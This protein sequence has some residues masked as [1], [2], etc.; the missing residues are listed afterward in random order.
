MI[1]FNA[2]DWFL[3]LLARYFWLTV[4]IAF[5]TAW[6]VA[7]LKLKVIRKHLHSLSIPPRGSFA[8]LFMVFAVLRAPL[9]PVLRG[10]VPAKQVAAFPTGLKWSVIVPC[11]VL[12]WAMVVLLLKPVWNMV[13]ETWRADSSVFDHL[14]VLGMALC[15]LALWL[16]N[17]AY[18]LFCWLSVERLE[19][20]VGGK[21]MLEQHRAIAGNSLGGRR[22]RMGVISQL[23]KE[24]KTTMNWPRLA[25]SNPQRV[26]G[27]ARWAVLVPRRLGRW[28]LW[29]YAGL[30]LV[31]FIWGDASIL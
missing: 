31:L 22:Q 9:Q 30:G 14:M 20:R 10:R 5:V 27:W 11:Q 12:L 24:P 23:L 16:G 2:G 3:G 1:E 15:A 25:A 13:S 21:P 6:C 8:P 7:R 29:A 17:G 18:T 26:P 28:L 19:Q 4:A